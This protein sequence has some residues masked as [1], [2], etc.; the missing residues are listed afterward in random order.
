[1]LVLETDLFRTDLF[2]VLA[3]INPIYIFRRKAE[4][5]VTSGEVRESVPTC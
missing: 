4:L 2:R 3:V 5:V 1:L